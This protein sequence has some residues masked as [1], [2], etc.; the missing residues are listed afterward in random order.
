MS[1]KDLVIMPGPR[2]YK[3]RNIQQL[4]ATKES[5]INDGETLLAEGGMDEL[6]DQLCESIAPPEATGDI[7][8]LF[9]RP[10]GQ[11]A[12]AGGQS[13]S[14]A[15]G[16]VASAAASAASASPPAAT[17]RRG[18][19]S[20]ANAV[21]APLVV[22]ADNE[23]E[24]STP[25]KGGRQR[26]GKAGAAKVKPAPKPVAGQG[27]PSP[28][29]KGRPAKTAEQV[30]VPFLTEVVDL[31]RSCAFFSGK[32]KHA[33]RQWLESSLKLAEAW[34]QEKD[35]LPATRCERA[36]M[37]KQMQVVAELF[38]V[39]NKSGGRS[40]EFAAS[41]KEQHLFIAMDPVCSSP[42]P[43][44]MEQMHHEDELMDTE[45]SAQEVWRLLMTSVLKDFWLHPTN[46]ITDVEKHIEIAK[47]DQCLFL[48]RGPRLCQEPQ[49]RR[50][51]VLSAHRQVGALAAVRGGHDVAG[52]VHHG[53][54]RQGGLRRG[55]R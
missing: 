36:V 44:F 8:D 47:R 19:G 51:A 22:E 40:E 10:A 53:D 7:M 24:N 9:A 23:N 50:G 27:D 3:L 12:S 17:T 31:E 49:A 2:I 14:S 16:Q 6:F 33:K 1:G 37:Y 29:G 32:E 25:K 54:A 55:Q 20:W 15:A 45:V 28:A 34:T 48:E 13:S 52:P 38:R 39:F 4:R 11:V 5:V 21:A 35:I 26:K 30:I 46:T 43:L 42:I 41:M 18:W